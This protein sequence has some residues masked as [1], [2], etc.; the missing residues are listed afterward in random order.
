LF[1]EAPAAKR[2]KGLFTFSSDAQSPFSSAVNPTY[3]PRFIEF[4]KFFEAAKLGQAKTAEFWL[5][6]KNVRI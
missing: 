4:K 3:E 1:D 5:A 6:H 2:T